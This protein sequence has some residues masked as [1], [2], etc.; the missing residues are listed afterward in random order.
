[1]LCELPV[2]LNVKVN[3]VDVAKKQD[4]GINPDLE[5]A[6]NTMLVDMRTNEEWSLTD[7]MKI[8]DRALKL[9]AIKLKIADEGWGAGLLDDNDDNE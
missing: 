9:E 4:K 6:I 8:L 3:E 2:N 5:D 7:K 1:M